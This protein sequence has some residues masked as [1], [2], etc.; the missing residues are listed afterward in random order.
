MLRCVPYL[1]EG[2]RVDNYREI[3]YHK[4]YPGTLCEI[5]IKSN[6]M[7][8]VC[9]EWILAFTAVYGGFASEQEF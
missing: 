1:R 4:K 7:D 9:L 6:I 2:N 3:Q 8:V 5:R